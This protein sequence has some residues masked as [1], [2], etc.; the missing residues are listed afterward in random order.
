MLLKRNWSGNHSIGAPNLLGRHNAADDV[1]F[2]QAIYS[3][4]QKILN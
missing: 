2:V 1:L 3:S 4:T